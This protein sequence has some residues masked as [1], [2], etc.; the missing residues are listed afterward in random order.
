MPESMY[1]GV[2]LF[3]ADGDGRLDILLL[4]GA[5]PNTGVGNRLYLQTPDGKFRD[6]SAGSGLDFDGYKVGVAV[7]DV[8]NDR[9][10]EVLITQLT[11]ARLLRNTGD[12]KFPEIS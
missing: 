1:G 10:P 2:A 11:G 6:A 4:Q 8:D 3:D 5:G 12:G 9:R 7:G